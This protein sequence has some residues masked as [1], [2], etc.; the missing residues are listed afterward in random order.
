MKIA[1]KI[2][3]KALGILLI[4]VAIIVAGLGFQKPVQT[5]PTTQIDNQIYE[6][7]EPE[8]WVGK[9]LPII[10]YIDIDEELKD[11]N[12]LVLFYHQDCPDCRKAVPELEKAVFEDVDFNIAI[13]EVPPYGSP[14]ETNCFYSRLLEAKEWFITTPVV[15]LLNNS[16][17][18][19]VWEANVP[20]IKDVYFNFAAHNN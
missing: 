19:A 20:N 3:L 15:I 5:V 6:V 12:W 1:N 4:A 10:D 13:I 14:I 17:V 2:L 7:L 16:I 8:G 11:G 9:K 18:S